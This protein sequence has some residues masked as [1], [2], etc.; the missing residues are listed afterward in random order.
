MRNVL[1]F[2]L[3][4]ISVVIIDMYHGNI[5]A[6]P[7][8]HVHPPNILPPPQ[9]TKPLWTEASFY[10]WESEDIIKA[11]KDKGLEVEDVKP[12]Y[13]MGPTTPREGKIFL[14]PSFGRNIGGYVSSYNSEDDFND[15]KNYYLQMNKNPES[16]AWWIF[17]KDNILVLISGKIPEEK[18]REYEKVLKE[19]DKK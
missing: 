6:Q 12:G 16:P 11:F 2:F 15:A 5:Y 18:A 7:I 13:T 3:C 9:P 17:E 1:S 4:V 8:F 19:M 14:I 10:K